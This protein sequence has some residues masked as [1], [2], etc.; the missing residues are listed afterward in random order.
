MFFPKSS[1][2]EQEAMMLLESRMANIN[3]ANPVQLAEYQ[4]FAESLKQS[5]IRNPEL[6][7]MLSEGDKKNG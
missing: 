2:T 1:I 5:V 3:P 4:S 6:I 7:R